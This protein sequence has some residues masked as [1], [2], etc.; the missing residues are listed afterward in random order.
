M[1]IL[2]GLV[3]GKLVQLVL[4]KR[5]SPEVHLSGYLCE[6]GLFGRF[7]FGIMLNSMGGLFSVFTIDESSFPKIR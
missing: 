2:S 3:L 6:V 4:G 5:F 1:R 7:T